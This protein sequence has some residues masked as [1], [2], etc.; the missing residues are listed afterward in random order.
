[1]IETICF[2]PLLIPYAIKFYT[3]IAI[4]V[5]KFPPFRVHQQV[6]YPG[7]LSQVVCVCGEGGGGAGWWGRKLIL[8]FHHNRH[9]RLKEL[10]KR[11]YFNGA[12]GLRGVTCFEKV[13][14][15]WSS[16]SRCKQFLGETGKQEIL[17]QI[18]RKF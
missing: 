16:G 3:P 4:T 5:V 10:K 1:M 9:L 11:K 12:E 7:F 14:F 18:F 13:M 17:Q 6:K 8:L 2:N 15:G